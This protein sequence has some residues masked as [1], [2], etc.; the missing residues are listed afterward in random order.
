MNSDA[1]IDRLNVLTGDEIADVAAH[2]IAELVRKDGQPGLRRMG[3]A[4]RAQ[5]AGAHA[6]LCGWAEDED[7]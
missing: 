6:E 4:L 2:A 3:S 5:D 1:I 7:Y